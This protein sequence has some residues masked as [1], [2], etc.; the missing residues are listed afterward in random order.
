M[1]VQ[2]DWIFNDQD[3][4]LPTR[5][6][7]VGGCSRSFVSMLSVAVNPNV[8][9]CVWRLDFTH[10]NGAVASWLVSLLKCITFRELVEVHREVF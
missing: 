3:S 5:N 4:L 6:I 10:A 7:R 8:E 9:I 2:I 1:Y